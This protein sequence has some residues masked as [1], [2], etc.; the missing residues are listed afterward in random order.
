MVD[1]SK[2]IDAIPRWFEGIHLNW[3]ENLLWSRSSSDPSNHRGKEGKEDDKIALTGVREG[4][5]EVTHITWSTLR[6][7]S[8]A[9]ATALYT[10]GVRRGDRVVVVG[11]N[12]VETLAAFIGTT[13]L[14]ALFSS[15]STDMGVQGILQRTVQVD[16]KV[17]EHS[18]RIEKVPNF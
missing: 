11:A 14:G 13:W 1:E 2:P 7:L 18:A 16:P 15:S 10:G 8:A 6:R 5:T 9:Y 4:A 3:A 12:S 17:C